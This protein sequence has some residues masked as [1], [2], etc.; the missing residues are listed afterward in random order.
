MLYNPIPLPTNEPVNDPVVYDDVKELNALRILPDSCDNNVSL[1]NKVIMLLLDEV[2]K[3]FIDE[4]NVLNDVSL[5][6]FSPLIEIEP[7]TMTEPVKL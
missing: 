2:T 4:L 5:L 3:E 1:L 7:D 6:I